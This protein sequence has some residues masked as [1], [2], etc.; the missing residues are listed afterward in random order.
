M[1]K[2]LISVL[3]PMRYKN[4]TWPH[5]PR[6]YSIGYERQTAVH[7]VPMGVYTMQD[8]GR[9]CRVMRGEGEFF[10]KDAYA[11]FKKLATVFYDG[12]PGTLFHPVWMTTSAYFTRLELTQEPRED[13]VAYAFEFREGFN[14]Y[15]GMEKVFTPDKG[16]AVSAAAAAQYHTV[17]SGDTLWAIGN[18]YGKSVQ[19]LLKL[20]PGI[21]NPNLIRV[22]QKV[23]VR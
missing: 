4:F 11:T 2:E 10:G 13:H 5:N 19:E 1:K 22:G 21:S 18:K 9:T 12:G 8:L 16:A 17:V 7:K 3:A 23:R 20:N 14:G 15:G 6:T